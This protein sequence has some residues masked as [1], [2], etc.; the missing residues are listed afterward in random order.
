[1]FP[2]SVDIVFRYLVG[3]HG[4]AHAGCKIILMMEKVNRMIYGSVLAKMNEFSNVNRRHSNFPGI[5]FISLALRFV[6]A[7]FLFKKL[8]NRVTCQDLPT[9]YRPIQGAL[10]NPFYSVIRTQSRTINFDQNNRHS[11]I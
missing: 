7:K 3:N 6:S 2:A 1:M 11:A 10:I 9:I 4:M 8:P 5:F